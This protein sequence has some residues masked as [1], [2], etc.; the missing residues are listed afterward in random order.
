MTASRAQAV[1]AIAT[2]SLGAWG[3]ATKKHVREAIAPVQQ[4]VNQVQKDTAANKA[5]IGDLDRSVASADEKATDAGRRAQE[6]ANAAAQAN[7]AAQ[8]AQSRADQANN[9]ATQAMNN[10]TQVSQ[11]LQNLY[12][13]TLSNT[14]QVFFRV[15]Q[16]VLTPEAKQT[17]DQ[18]VANAGNMH[19]FVIE[20]E[21]F[22]DKTGGK[23]YNLELAR[24]RADAVVR[25]LT[26]DKNVP[27]RNVRELGVGS[28][29][30]NAENATRA[31]RKENRRVD[32]KIYSLNL[33]GQPSGANSGNTT[34][35]M[36]RTT[37]TATG[38]SDR[39][40]TTTPR[41]TSPNQPQQ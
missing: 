32:V 25:Y 23:A 33:S 21:G 27:L 29:F 24:R 14:T 17:L 11:Q 40:N 15:G 39:M 18:A 41:S 34:P 1:L 30:P 2:M 22:T 31:Q 36:N 26:V 35:E 9:T 4:Q 5:A 7:S 20:V 8:Q 37:P 16:S 38:T 13:Y 3:C 12:N 19:N 10:V 6:A 28:E